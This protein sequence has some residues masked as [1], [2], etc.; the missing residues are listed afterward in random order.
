MSVSEF[1][2]ESAQR[3]APLPERTRILLGCDY[4]P[5]QWD[6][7][8]WAHDVEL[9]VRAGVS[10]VA[11]NVFGWSHIEPRPGVFDFDDLDDV[12]AMLHSAG[13][14][15]NLGTGTASPPA[16]LS[17]QHPEILPVDADGLRAWHGGRQAYCPS[18]P[19]FRAAAATL[20]R[21][22]CRRYGSHPAVK[23]WHVSNELGAHNAL[24]YC[25]VSAQAFR[26]WLTAKYSTLERLNRAWG[27]TFWSQ[28]Y[29]DWSEI[30][31]PRRTL[32]SG[33][34][35]QALDFARFSSDEVLE[36][37]RVEE[38][39]VRECS[40]APVTTNLMVTAHIRT[41]DYWS[42]TPYLDVIAN[43]HYLDHRLPDPHQELSFAA[44]VTRGLAA[45]GPWMLMEQATGAVNWQPHN[46]S[47]AP[48]EMLR[49]SL[50]HVARGAD[51][52]CFFQWRASAQGAEKFHSAMVPHAGTESTKWHEV[53]ELARTLEAL[54]EV[55]G[56]RV[57]AEAALI[58]SWE[59]WWAT[60][61]DSHP[62]TEV[63]YIDQV[64]TIYR[65]LWDAGITVDI[66]PPGADLTGY[67]LVVVPTLYLVRD[68][69]ASAIVDFVAHGG[70]ALITFF[71]GIVDEDDRVRLGGYPGAFRTLLG[72]RIDEFFPL[73]DGVRVHLDNGTCAAVWSE[74]IESTGARVMSRFLDGPL[75]GSPAVTRQRHGD[76]LAWYLGTGLDPSA[77]RSVVDEVAA[78]AGISAAGSAT[79][80]VERVVR[81][82]DSDEYRFYINHTEQ[83]RDVD[84]AGYELICKTEV[85]RLQLPPGA[86][87]VLRSP[88]GA[89]RGGAR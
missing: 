3:V 69:H 59:C 26:G 81:S 61:L 82:N 86:V 63:R 89:A 88:R 2:G 32:S 62:S 33:N 35:A 38:R 36:C 5:E 79:A 51:S 16:W 85:A 18:S 60:D 54:G 37:Y 53:L 14:G 43:D 22:V 19:V 64:H 46:L 75:P 11:I 40:A 13:I 52:V 29:G 6:R 30:L 80:G 50:T 73:G 27:T 12:I 9:M 55:A 68:E 45:G 44:D 65:A 20:A 17:I 34:P 25:D 10:M 28:G 74:R 1:A 21:E 42:W 77:L 67:R 4:N 58:F 23:L 78:D 8:T 66:V 76:G 57:V 31:P 39:V 84:D 24:C 71:S 7:D 41:Q 70:T 87:R 72:I 83:A 49:N 15:V 48:G 56:S 47:K